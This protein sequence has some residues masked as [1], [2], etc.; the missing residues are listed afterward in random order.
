M[1]TG[2]RLVVDPGAVPRA[3]ILHGDPTE[4]IN[5]DD[6]MPSRHGRAVKHHVTSGITADHHPAG[7]QPYAMAGLDAG[8]HGQDRPVADD[9]AHRLGGAGREPDDGAVMQPGLGQRQ[10]GLQKTTIH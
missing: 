10:I 9:S 1:R 5:F 7:R 4:L 6:A 3:Q 2:Y 8:H